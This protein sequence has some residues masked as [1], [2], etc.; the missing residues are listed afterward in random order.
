[1]NI[2][3]NLINK[4]F[5][6]PCLYFIAFLSFIGCFSG[7]CFLTNIPVHFRFQY[8]ILS[9][10]IF[11]FYF[12]CKTINKEETKKFLILTIVLIILNGFEVLKTFS[13]PDFAKK[14]DITIALINVYS[15]NEDYLTISEELINRLPDIIIVNEM[16]DDW[17]YGL[18]SIKSMYSYSYE[19]ARDDNFGSA[20]YSKIPITNI[21]KLNAGE[22]QIPFISADMKYKNIPFE[23][24]AGHVPPPT[25]QEYFL[26]SKKVFKNLARYIRE[27]PNNYL[28]IGDFNMTVYSSTYK[29]FVKDSGLKNCGNVFLPSWPTFFTRP[30]RINIDHILK[31]DCFKVK[32]YSIGKKFGSNHYPVYVELEVIDGV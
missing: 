2:N 30:F 28:I 13:F 25:N 11:L 15:K 22:L 32:K 17:S 19:I 14:T 10:I 5:I 29:K 18:E 21:R 16:N 6:K 31:S 27:Y 7:M 3:T 12:F 9:L 24:I 4:F 26:N 23:I 1:M 8:F 20:I